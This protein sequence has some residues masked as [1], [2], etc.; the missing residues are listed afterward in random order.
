MNTLKNIENLLESL[1]YKLK[2]VTNDRRKMLAEI[3]NLREQ[4][5]ERDKD[6]VK[7]T[8]DMKI[9]LEAVQLDALR[10]EQERIRVDVKFQN[11]NDKLISL[12]SDEKSC[13]G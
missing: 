1:T 6:A 5:V 11:L 13:G 8:Q 9:E 3:S 7:I 12:V 2:T 10:S 4:L